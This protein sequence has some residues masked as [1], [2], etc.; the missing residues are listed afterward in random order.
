M[1]KDEIMTYENIHIDH[2][3]PISVFNL[4][5]EEEFLEC[6]N[7]TNLQPLLIKDNLEKSN[8]WNEE[9]EKYWKENIKNNNKYY[10][11]YLIN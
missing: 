2:I 8:K 6:C 1:A 7:Y 5:N 3:K 9:K 4:E 11:I 10:E